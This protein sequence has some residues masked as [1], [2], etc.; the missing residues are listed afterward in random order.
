MDANTV[1]LSIVIP[2]YNEENRIGSALE[3]ILSYLAEKPFEYEVIVVDDG[4]RDRTVE[5][6]A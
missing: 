2:A 1:S 3:A 4:S 6:A 5:V